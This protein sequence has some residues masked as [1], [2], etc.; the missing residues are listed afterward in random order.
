MTSSAT[1]VAFFMAE[2]KGIVF[3]AP[4]MT[5]EE[6]SKYNML[7]YLTVLALVA[8]GG[9][10]QHINSVK[11]RLKKMPLFSRT[12]LLIML[13]CFINKRINQFRTLLR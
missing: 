12:I 6:L 8:V 1:I 10:I 3:H 13:N 9:L 5:I 2:S 11:Q 7:N 4:K